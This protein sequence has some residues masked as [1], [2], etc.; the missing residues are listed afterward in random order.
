[1]TRDESRDL[2]P[3]IHACVASATRYNDNGSFFYGSWVDDKKHGKGLY[4]TLEGS[5]YEG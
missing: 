2:T 5:R 4:Y 3:C 1:M